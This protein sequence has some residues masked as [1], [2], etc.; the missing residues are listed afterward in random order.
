MKREEIIDDIIYATSSE[1]AI[2]VLKKLVNQQK[3]V[4]PS[5]KELY[6]KLEKIFPHFIDWDKRGEA[7]DWFIDFFRLYL[8]NQQKEVSDEEINKK[9]NELYPT[10]KPTNY[11][12]EGKK[13]G[14]K[15]G[16]KW[17]RDKLTK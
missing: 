4:L 8:A 2:K 6:S 1:E 7:L 5:R 9:A 16:A 15:I 13:V 14:F 17:M 12:S 11:F 3:E 10:V